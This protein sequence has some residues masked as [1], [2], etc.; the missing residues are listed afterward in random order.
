MLRSS[1]TPLEL[2]EKDKEMKKYTVT[3]Q[4]TMEE[5]TAIQMIEWDLKD[6]ISTAVLPTIGAELAPLTFTVKKARN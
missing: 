6:L 1:S 5:E 4:I 3:F 2:T